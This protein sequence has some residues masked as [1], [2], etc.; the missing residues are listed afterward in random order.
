MRKEVEFLNNTRYERLVDSCVST[1]C[2]PESI[3]QLKS[4]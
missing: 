1:L 2:E 3:P 4:Y